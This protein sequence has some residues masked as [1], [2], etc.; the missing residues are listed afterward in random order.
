VDAGGVAE[1]AYILLN[2]DAYKNIVQW[3]DLATSILTI[4]HIVIKFIMRFA[5]P[6]L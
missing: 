4:G 1:I 6:A 3:P 2:A 5:R